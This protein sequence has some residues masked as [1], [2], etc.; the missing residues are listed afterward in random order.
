MPNGFYAQGLGLL[1]NNSYITYWTLKPP[2]DSQAV[3][4]LFWMG[5]RGFDIFF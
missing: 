4:R 1:A 2:N 3:A 5:D